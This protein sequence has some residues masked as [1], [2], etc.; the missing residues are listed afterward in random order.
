[1]AS[2]QSRSP[3]ASIPMSTDSPL[4]YFAS[5]HLFTDFFSSSWVYTSL[6][7]IAGLLVLEQSVYR[8]KKGHL[9]GSKWTIP[10]IGKFA[11]SMSPSIEGYQRQWDSGE[12]SAISVFNMYVSSVKLYS[13]TSVASDLLLWPL[14]INIP[15]KSLILRP[16]LNHV[17]SHL[18]S[19][20]FV[21]ITGIHATGI[22]FI[23]II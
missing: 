1:M 10:I 8:Y 7:V 20:F 3:S 14:Q 18:R 9:P 16:T 22:S 23:G 5:P 11:D 12:L 15:A 17:L 6:A 19:K 13:I 4:Q 2:S 21:L